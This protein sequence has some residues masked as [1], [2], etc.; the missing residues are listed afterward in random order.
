M[1]FCVFGYHIC[2]LGSYF[3]NLDKLLTFAKKEQFIL[4]VY[5]V[6]LFSMSL[7]IVE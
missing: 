6:M 7:L 2:D 4:V 3:S 1:S 5:K